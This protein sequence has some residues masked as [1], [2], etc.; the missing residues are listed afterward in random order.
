MPILEAPTSGGGNVTFK[1]AYQFPSKHIREAG[2]AFSK[3]R[4]AP[5]FAKE[6]R[7][8]RGSKP[9]G[10][11]PNRIDRNPFGIALIEP[12]CGKVDGGCLV[13]ATCNTESRDLT[14]G[15]RACEIARSHQGSDE[16]AVFDKQTFYLLA[17]RN[18]AGLVGDI[19]DLLGSEASLTKESAKKK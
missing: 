10:R 13:G 6:Q 11:F 9:H 8:L 16:G 5:P 7:L 17:A 12:M 2:F 14:E 15:G 1:L 4:V 19:V 18:S 3:R